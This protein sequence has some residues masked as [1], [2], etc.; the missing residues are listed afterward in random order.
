[1]HRDTSDRYEVHAAPSLAGHKRLGSYLVD[2]GLINRGQVEVALND[3]KATGMKFGEVLA[4]RGWIKQQTVEYFMEKLVLPDRKP[5]TPTAP[6]ASTKAAPP[7]LMRRG[8][9][10]TPNTPTG[11]AHKATT[12]A[13]RAHNEQPTVRQSYP[14][15]KQ[16]PQEEGKKKVRK[17]PPITKPL[18]SNPSEDG[19]PWVG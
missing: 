9:R 12:S 13:A 1:M 8:V 10:H 14:T 16:Q 6:K 15:I 5:L 18:P 19:V 17:G 4:T 11:L 3:Q 2:A 7:D